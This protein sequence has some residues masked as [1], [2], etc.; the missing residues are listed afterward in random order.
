MKNLFV[1]S[2]PSKAPFLPFEPTASRIKVSLHQLINDLLTGLQP[3]AMKRNNVV[4]NGVPL[5][6][7]FVA[8]EN[9]LAYALWNFLTGIITNKQN[10]CIHV[11]TLVDDERT[12]ICVREAGAYQVALSLSNH[13]MAV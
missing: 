10:E 4:L 6:L 3:L 13:R 1:A 2:R 7:C 11:Q 8:E 9:L 5:G 12:M